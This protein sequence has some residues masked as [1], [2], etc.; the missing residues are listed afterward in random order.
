MKETIFSVERAED[1]VNDIVSFCKKWGLWKD[2][3]VY[4]G[5]KR[6]T[7]FDATKCDVFRSHTFVVVSEEP[8]SEKWTVFS[9]PDHLLDMTFEGPLSMLLRHGEYEVEVCDLSDV[10]KK[11]ITG[12]ESGRVAEKIADK[13][14]ED[15][16]KY[17][18]DN[19][20]WDPA[21][22]DS[23]EEYLELKQYCEPDY[24]KPALKNIPGDFATREEYLEFLEKALV[25]K[26]TAVEEY[27]KET[28]WECNEDIWDMDVFYDDGA[29]AS[30]IIEEFNRILETYGLWYE[31]GSSWCLTTYRI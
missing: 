22:F 30:H 1:L 12:A 31:L 4:T 3:T 28:A 7:D 17:I 23:Y 5:G 21:E 27:Y 26:V 16:C 2:T 29:I 19:Q 8:H 25:N 10:A 6:Y 13:I 18:E 14:L 9:N 15:T 24:E 20:G 11:Y